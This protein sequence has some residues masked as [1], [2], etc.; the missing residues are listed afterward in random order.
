MTG[1]AFSFNSNYSGFIGILSSK[2]KENDRKNSFLDTLQE[3]GLIDH[4]TVS[5]YVNDAPGDKNSTIK[6]GSYD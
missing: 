3:K 1:N 4:Q 6:F 5:F 2:H